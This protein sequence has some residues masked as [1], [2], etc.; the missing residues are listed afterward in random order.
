MSVK[1]YKSTSP[2]AKTPQ[3]SWYLGILN[4]REINRDGTDREWTIQSKHHQR[5][6]LLSFELY[7]TP[8][9]WW[10]FM[11]LNPNAIKDPIYDFNAG[12]IIYIPTRDRLENI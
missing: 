10:V 9:Y 3:T 7:G 12:M 8:D 2:Y 5:P 1:K 11:E 4:R 6:D